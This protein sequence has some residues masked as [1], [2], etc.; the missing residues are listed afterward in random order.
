MKKPMI[1]LFSISLAVV[2]LAVAGSALL[3]FVGNQQ[4]Y[5]PMDHKVRSIE[6]AVLVPVESLGKKEPQINGVTIVPLLS[7]AQNGK[8]EWG[9]EHYNLS[10][11]DT[12]SKY[13]NRVL[14]IKV[15]NQFG[16]NLKP[17][18]DTLKKFGQPKDYIF[19]SD[20][21]RPIRNLRKSFPRWFYVCN[22]PCLLKSQIFDALFIPTWAPLHGDAL[23][24]SWS[25]KSGT[26]V[27]DSLIKEAARRKLFVWLKADNLNDFTNSKYKK[28]ASG[29]M[30]NS[31]NWITSELLLTT[32]K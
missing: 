3:N 6:F 27:P 14:A 22:E 12:L 19:L 10:I 13:K 31:P 21:D 11:A 25:A 29:V 15:Q 20:Y 7:V 17:L 28:Y 24:A 8:R 1:Y 32:L 2:T 4:Q 16:L 5:Q 23:I 9:I 18:T 30:T 26:P